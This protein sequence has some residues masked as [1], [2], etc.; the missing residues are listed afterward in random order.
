MRRSGACPSEG[1]VAYVDPAT[2]GE[3]PPYVQR[4]MLVKAGQMIVLRRGSALPQPTACAP[5]ARSG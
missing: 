3:L 5:R 1:W 2:E 4:H